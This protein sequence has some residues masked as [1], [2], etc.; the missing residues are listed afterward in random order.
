MR[1]AQIQRTQK[2]KNKSHHMKHKYLNYSESKRSQSSLPHL[3]IKNT[4]FRSWLTNPNLKKCKSKLAEVAISHQPPCTTGK[5][6]I[7]VGQ[8]N[9]PRLEVNPTE[10]TQLPLARVSPLAEGWADKS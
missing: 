1:R 5:P 9:F 2:G 3:I 10:V 7:S 6:Q 8:I 4:K